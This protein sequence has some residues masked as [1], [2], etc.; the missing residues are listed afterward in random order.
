VITPELIAGIVGRADAPD[1]YAP[2]R[3]ACQFFRIDTVVRVA[4]FLAQCGHESG[5]FV[6]LEENLN[7]SADRLL[8]VFPKYFRSGEMAAAYARKPQAIANRVYANRMGN[9][10]E[11][12]GDGWAYRGGGLIQLTGAEN[13]RRCGDSIGVNLLRAPELVRTNKTYAA[14][15]AAWFW[16]D[17][18]CNAY[19]DIGDFEGL[20][21]RIN[22]GLNGLEDRVAW[23]QKVEGAM[24]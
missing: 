14:I 11:A 22:G 23:L 19:A 17:R 8:A 21:R 18:G 13:Y 10:D 9:G 1:W 2:L 7:Y 4:P 15:S 24:A 20:T 5:G 6:S 16:A 3:D 12:S